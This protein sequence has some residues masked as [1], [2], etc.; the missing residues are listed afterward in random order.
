[1]DSSKNAGSR[2]VSAA[3]LLLAPPPGRRP[4]GEHS[5]SRRRGCR[6]AV[7]PGGHLMGLEWHARVR[8]AGP[9]GTAILAS[10]ALGVSMTMLAGAGTSAAAARS[11]SA[12]ARSTAPGGTISTVAG[13][14]GGPGG[15]TSV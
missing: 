2:H 15:A 12:A 11:L 6:L 13:G 8:L 1:M 9:A 10:A 7:R 14:V 3:K 4:G 5:R